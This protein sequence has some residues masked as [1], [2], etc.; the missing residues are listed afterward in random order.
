MRNPTERSK[1]FNDELLRTGIG[2]I[3]NIRT[4][5]LAEVIVLHLLIIFIKYVYL[6]FGNFNFKIYLV[7][8]VSEELQ[9]TSEIQTFSKLLPF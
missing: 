2:R 9:K 7:K 8:G 1:I 6:I 5:T 3:K 4:K